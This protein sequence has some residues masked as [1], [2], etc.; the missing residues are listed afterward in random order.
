MKRLNSKYLLFFAIVLSCFDAWGQILENGGRIASI[1]QI[2]WHN[3]GLLPTTR[4]G[5]LQ[6]ATPTQTQFLEIINPNG[7][8]NQQVQSAL[9]AAVGRAGTTLIYFPGGYYELTSPIQIN[10]TQNLHNIVFQG[11]GA[12]ATILKFTVGRD[13]YCFNIRGQAQG[14]YPINNNINKDENFFTCQNHDFAIGDWVHFHE[15][16]FPAEDGSDIGQIT[17]IIGRDLG[18]HRFTMKDSASKVYLT[19]LSLEAYQ[20]NPVTNIG[21]EN[22]TIIRRESDKST[23][24]H[25]TEGSNVF[26]QYAV[27]CWLRGVRLSNTSRHHIHVNRSSHIEVNGCFIEGALDHGGGSYGYGICLETSSTNCLFENN[28]FYNLRH[29]MGIASGA[30][31]NVF[32]YNYSYGQYSTVG[33]SQYSDSDL[34]LHGKYSFANLYESNYVEWIEADHEHGENGPY[35]AFVRNKVHRDDNIHLEYSPISSV[36]G[37]ET[38]HVEIDLASLPLWDEYGCRYGDWMTHEEANNY[39]KTQFTLGDVSYYYS[40]TPD[41]IGEMT[42]PSIGPKRADGYPIP[43]NNIPA[44]E[45]DLANIHYYGRTFNNSPM[46]FPATSSY[47]FTSGPVD[48]SLTKINSD[49]QITFINNPTRSLPTGMYIC[50]RYELQTEAFH[51]PSFSGSTTF[52]WLSK[53]GYSYANPNYSDYYLNS[54]STNAHSIMKTC[55]YHLKFNSIGQTI[56]EWAPCHPSQLTFQYGAMG[57]SGTNTTSGTLAHDEAW[58]GTHTLT[59][60][61]TIPSGKILYILPDANINVASGKKIIVNGI[62]KAQGTSSE[63]ITFNRSGSSNWWGIKFEDSS[64]DAECILEYCTV[65]HA[66]WGAY[67]YKSSPAIRNCILTNNTTGIYTSYQTA[68]QDICENEIGY[69]WSGVSLTNISGVIVE[70]ND[71]DV[72]HSSFVNLNCTTTSNSIGIHDNEMR[73]CTSGNGVNLNSSSPNFVGNFV[74][75]NYGYGIKCLSSS[76]ELEGDYYSS[77][78][79]NNVV[80]YNGSYGI[81]IDASSQPVLGH[82]DPDIAQ[83][84]YYSNGTY[85]VYSLFASYIAAGNCYRGDDCTPNIYGMVWFYPTLCDNPNPD[86]HSLQKSLAE[87]DYKGT[88]EVAGDSTVNKEARLHYDRGYELEQKGEYEAALGEYNF[89]IAEYPQTLEAELSLNRI[90]ICNDKTKS[91]QATLSYMEAIATDYS[92]FRVGGKA[93]AYLTKQLIRDGDYKTAL[94][95]CSDLVQ[96]FPQSDLAKDGLFTQWQIYFDGFQDMKSASDAM[97]QYESSFPK[98]FSLA[99][100]KIAMGEWTREMEKDFTESLPKRGSE[101]MTE[102]ADVEKPKAFALIGNYPNPFN[103]ETIIKYATPKGSHVLI[104]IH[105][106]LGQRIRRLLDSDV[107]AGYHDL[108]WNG[109]NEVGQKV[110][111]GIYLCRMQAGK[112]MKTQKMTLLP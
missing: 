53:L 101:E 100:M 79:G 16:A 86:P 9:N 56:N 39:N 89:V 55:F 61:V 112:F 107:P 41:F 14:A 67:C 28:I 57:L 32:V 99:I 36:L 105:N 108:V 12:D 109:R 96:N 106:V 43:P 24:G 51:C 49:I 30:N 84:S 42:F 72:H 66:S 90:T 31:S 77:I 7:D 92:N 35:N 22:L 85:D 80:A 50:D 21:I 110:S 102:G 88:Q 68:P 17:Q 78:P 37:C 26:L 104:E 73:N 2:R 71:N 64:L 13:G 3:A 6:P 75:D 34:C 60:D 81:Y 95:N 54:T 44:R 94:A 69:N 18:T 33:G 29:A 46:P 1:Y 40:A 8:V 47:A 98:D 27:N 10:S 15:D 76:P 25:Y 103:P 70:F 5:G 83:N 23:E 48:Y 4:Q 82:Y 38:H 74:Y 59:G 97:Q 87:A 52:A 20:I 19:S 65:Q 111:A 91:S 45:R 93:Q 58:C 11:A 62:L 63:P